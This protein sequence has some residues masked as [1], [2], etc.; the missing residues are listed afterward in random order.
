MIVEMAKMICRIG[1]S[2]GESNQTAHI[3]L[4]NMGSWVT[5]AL[6]IGV[7]YIRVSGPACHLQ[8]GSAPGF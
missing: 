5:A 3:S 6:K 1:G 7:P 4:K 8:N 2:L